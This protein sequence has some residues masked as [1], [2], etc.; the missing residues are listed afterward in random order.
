MLQLLYRQWFLKILFV[1]NFVGTIWGFQWYKQQLADTSFMWWPIVPDS[2]L[3]SAFFTLAL[4]LILINKKIRWFH[5]LA[6]F[7][8][9][10]YGIWA[11]AVISDFWLIGG[12]IRLIEVMLFLSHIG[13]AAEGILYLPLAWPGK[14][15]WVPVVLFTW[16]NDIADYV[17]GMH[18][19]FFYN[20]QEPFG[21][22]L[23]LLLSGFLTIA[24]LLAGRWRQGNLEHDFARKV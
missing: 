21:L 18:P 7:M 12:E 4:F 2:P 9:I 15:S 1:I 23:A 24:A 11:V 19:Y 22:R 3:S 8:S 13:M 16:I 14:Y 17:F 5:L 10:K 6:C 20:G